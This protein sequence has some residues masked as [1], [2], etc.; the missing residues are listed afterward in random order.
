LNADGQTFERHL[1]IKT[2]GRIVDWPLPGHKKAKKIRANVRKAEGSYSIQVALPWIYLE[3]DPAKASRL[4]IRVI[5][6]EFVKGET[7]N[8]LTYQSLWSGKLVWK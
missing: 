4:N 8:E 7:R 6:N 2:N 3:V 1:W 5:R